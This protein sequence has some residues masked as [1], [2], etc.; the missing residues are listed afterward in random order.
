MKYVE[1]VLRV[2]GQARTS[3]RH[4]HAVADE[5]GEA[6]QH[7][8]G[9]FKRGVDTFI[10]YLDA[11]GGY[12]YFAIEDIVEFHIRPDDPQAVAAK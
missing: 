9:Q 3:K 10:G 1:V 11:D 8:V 4:T 12:H 7:A 5:T 6:L 2:R